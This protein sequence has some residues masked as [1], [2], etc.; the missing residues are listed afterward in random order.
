MQYI[1]IHILW[2]SWRYG[3]LHWMFVLVDHMFAVSLE[4]SYMVL[5]LIKPVDVSVYGM[6]FCLDVVH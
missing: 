2:V 3:Y 4:S 6:D 1:G 5:A